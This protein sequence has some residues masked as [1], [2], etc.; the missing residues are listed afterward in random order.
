M[1]APIHLTRPL[2]ARGRD[3]GRHQCPIGDCTWLLPA[4]KLMCLDHW[5]RVPEPLKRA[6]YAAYANGDGVGSD[7]LAAAHA[8]AIAAVERKL[9]RA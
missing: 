7:E 3:I 5:R 1:S 9:A 2:A 6:V 8:A 4:A